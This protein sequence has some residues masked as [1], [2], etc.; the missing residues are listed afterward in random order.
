MP[1]TVV[2]T[3]SSRGIG[4][5]TAALFSANGYNV[6]INYLKS[7]GKATDLCRALKKNGGAIAVCADV[8]DPN[9]AEKLITSAKSAFGGI[10]VLINNAGISRSGLITDFTYEQWNS[11]FNTNV[12]SVF[13]CCK[14]V[15]PYMIHNK[16]GC[17]LNISS[18][19]GVTGASCEVCY[20]STK[21]AIIGLTKALAKEVG[22]SGIRVNCVAPGLIDTD[23]NS[24]LTA[25]DIRALTDET[26][27]SV[28]GKPEDIA[29]TLLFLANGNSSFITGQVIGVNGGF[30]I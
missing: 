19:W 9:E 25:D 3:G 14:A 7:E 17:I 16:S 28:M 30:L 13:N 20:S 10:D 23:M 29:Q 2:I 8:S 12:G 21:A 18:M 11:M 1:K 6:V 4:A 5:A 26:P 22:P 27:L 24:A 15:L